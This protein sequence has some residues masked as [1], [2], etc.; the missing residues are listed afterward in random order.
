MKHGLILAAPK[1]QVIFFEP[2][3]HRK[4]AYVCR[5]ATTPETWPYN[6][7]RIQF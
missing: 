5:S 4:T 1:I 3:D 7:T 2:K 6:C